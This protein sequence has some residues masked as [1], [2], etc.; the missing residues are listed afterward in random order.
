MDQRWGSL[1]SLRVDLDEVAAAMDH[2]DR[3]E[4]DHFLNLETGEV[5]TLSAALIEAVRSGVDPRETD[6]AE[7]VLDDQP[8]AEAAA[9]DV[10]GK[11]FARIPEGTWIDMR[12]MRVRFVRAIKTDGV[13]Q[14]FA[15]AVTASDGGRRFRRLLKSYPQLSAAWYRF[16]ARQKREWARQW[17]ER[18]GVE[19][20]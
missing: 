2:M 12:E 19:A 4:T 7:W 3:T 9:G 13:L 8:L 17:L 10:H 16:E 11:G 6:L 5:V 1:K 14:Q 20:V 15:E 18:I